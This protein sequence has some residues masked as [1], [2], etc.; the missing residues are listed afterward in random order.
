M[1]SP[2]PLQ[3][4]VNA[5]QAEFLQSQAKVKCFMGGRGTG[6]STVLGLH[7][8]M[9]FRAMPRAKSVMIGTSYYALMVNTVP[10]MEEAWAYCGLHEYDPKTGLGHYVVGKKPPS[11][12]PKPWMPARDYSRCITFINGYTIQLFS[13][14]MALRGGNFDCGDS[15]ESALL[16]REVI[17]TISE[18]SIRGNIYRYPNQY[19]HHSFCHFTSSPWTLQGNWIF[20]IEDN[21]LQDLAAVKA[22]K[23]R[24]QDVGYHFQEARTADNLLVLG[25]DYLDRMKRSLSHWEYAIEI[26][27]Y[28][29]SKLPNGYYPA[30]DE[31]I[32]LAFDTVEWDYSESGRLITKGDTFLSPDAKL[33]L[34]FDF[35]AAFTSLIVCQQRE[36]EAGLEFRIGDNIFVKEGE[37]EGKTLVVALVDR[38][39]EAYKNHRLKVV[40]I[41]GDRNGNARS[42]NTTLTTY[43][44]ILQRFRQAGWECTSMVSGLDMEHESR[45]HLINELLAEKKASTPRIRFHA[46]RAKACF[47]SCQNAP[48]NP[49][50]TKNKADERK[51]ALPQEL[52]THLSDTLDYIL[53]RLYGKRLYGG[54]HEIWLG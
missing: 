52:A 46:E 10:A 43:E 30:L 38:F 40:D 51:K 47:I 17:K 3:I 7:N 53:T 25:E 31:N 41:Y 33:L 44:Q 11:E 34:S 45:H 48:I 54:A 6:K 32:H 36:T 9:K 19:L 1:D 5:K 23:I 4:Y 28:R 29:L 27:N 39:L 14:E 21:M 49:D 18:A 35:N 16:K 22:G 42:H 12:W 2:K 24:P 50:F 20:E 26:E 13:Q 37:S 8:Y 15:D